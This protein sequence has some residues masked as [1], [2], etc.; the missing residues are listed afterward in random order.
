MQS[1]IGTPFVIGIPIPK[2]DDHKSGLAFALL[3]KRDHLLDYDEGLNE[4]E[5][6]P[7]SDQVWIEAIA[8]V[9]ENDQMLYTYIPFI[10]T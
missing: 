2:G 7:K 6:H 3:T 5:V 9:D 4:K 10:P 1:A 8:E